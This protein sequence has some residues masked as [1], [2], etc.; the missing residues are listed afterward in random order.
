M[1][2]KFDHSFL[3]LTELHASG[4][5]ST[6]WLEEALEDSHS[7]IFEITQKGDLYPVFFKVG[8]CKAKIPILYV[9]EFDG[10]I[11]SKQARK[12]TLKEIQKFW[13]G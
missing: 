1:E 2:I 11:V 6:T 13:C 10:S 12:T 8:F 4:I 3:S 5:R 7:R 9:F